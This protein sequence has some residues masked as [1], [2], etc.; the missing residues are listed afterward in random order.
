MYKVLDICQ[1]IIKYCNEKGYK[2]TNLKLQPLLYYIQL[3]FL[4]VK[5]EKCF[6]EDVVAWDAFPAVKEA[7]RE[8]KRYG[9]LHIY[10]HKTYIIDKDNLFNS[11]YEEFDE[12]I[13]SEEDKVLINEVIEEYANQDNQE[14]RERVSRESP[15][16]DAIRRGIGSVIDLEYYAFTYRPKKIYEDSLVNL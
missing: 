5:Y 15:Y 1:Y 11:H 10:N 12:N 8:Y 7:F 6:E 3:H 2:I 14:I 16:R 4:S 13:I 9:A